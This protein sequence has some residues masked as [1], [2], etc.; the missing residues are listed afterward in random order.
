MNVRASDGWADWVCRSRDFGI[1]NGALG[2]LS[3]IEDSLLKYLGGGEVID[4]SG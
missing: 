4:Y 2:Q 1:G 3:F